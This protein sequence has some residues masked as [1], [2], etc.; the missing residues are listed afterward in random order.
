M[1]LI[2]TNLLGRGSDQ[3]QRF[4]TQA[5][6][7]EALDDRSDV[8]RARRTLVAPAEPF[9]LAWAMLAAALFALSLKGLDVI[10]T[11]VE[12]RREM[13]RQLR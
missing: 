13:V 6:A 4:A 9:D 5:S 1:A 3:D 7:A 8:P 12:S 2:S 10:T 11:L